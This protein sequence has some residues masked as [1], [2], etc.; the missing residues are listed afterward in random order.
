MRV[1]RGVT[2]NR[3][4]KKIL[5]STKGYMLSY[6]KLYRRAREAALHAGKYNYDHI[7]KKQYQFRKIW[8]KRINSVCKQQNTN[9]SRFMKSLKNTGVVLDRKIL[10]YLAYN[11]QKAFGKFISEF[12]E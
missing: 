5:K 3:R 4:H 7:K 11:H 12:V 9:Y 1:K 6:S 10:A 8:I 2:K